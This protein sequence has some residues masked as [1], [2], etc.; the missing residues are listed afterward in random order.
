M[1]LSSATNL[2]SRTATAKLLAYVCYED[3]ARPS[4]AGSAK[5]RLD[6]SL[7]AKLP[8]LLQS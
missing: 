5:M 2:F 4:I 1:P 3:E 8:E 6:E 7:I